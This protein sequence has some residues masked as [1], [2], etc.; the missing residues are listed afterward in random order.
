VCSLTASQAG[1]ANFLA[2]PSA[3]ASLRVVSPGMLLFL[4]DDD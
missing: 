4:F 3:S 1:D 2:A